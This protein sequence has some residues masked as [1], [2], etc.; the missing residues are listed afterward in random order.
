MLMIH[1]TLRVSLRGRP[2][3]KNLY[4]LFPSGI[5]SRL[6]LLVQILNLQPF[7]PKK[8]EP[9]SSIKV[10]GRTVFLSFPR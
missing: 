7:L 5:I 3:E 10:S 6:S 2:C 8:P 4:H 1:K 9:G